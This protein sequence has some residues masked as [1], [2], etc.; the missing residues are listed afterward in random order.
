MKMNDPFFIMGRRLASWVRRKKAIGKW[1]LSNVASPRNPKT[2]ARLF[3]QCFRGV[4]TE[5][6]IELR[7]WMKLGPILGLSYLGLDRA[8][9]LATDFERFMSKKKKLIAECVLLCK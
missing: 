9:V 7:L 3:R 8:S 5:S 2:Y 1:A 4:L 6:V